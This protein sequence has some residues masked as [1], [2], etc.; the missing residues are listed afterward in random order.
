MFGQVTV[1]E[2]RLFTVTS[3]YLPGEVKAACFYTIYPAYMEDR[4]IVNI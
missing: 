4:N 2:T 1:G 3:L